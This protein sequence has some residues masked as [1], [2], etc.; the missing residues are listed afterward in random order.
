MG[1]MEEALE[2]GLYRL[3][4]HTPGTLS[5]QS[6]AEASTVSF[7][8]GAGDTRRGTSRAPW[9]P[10]ERWRTWGGS[11]VLSPSPSGTAQ[12]GHRHRRFAGPTLGLRSYASSQVLVVPRH[13]R[14]PMHWRGEG[15]GSPLRRGDSRARVLRFRT[16]QCNLQQVQ[17]ALGQYA[18]AWLR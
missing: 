1:R 16:V 14:R 5:K 13:N 2:E 9:R 3:R 10:S 7:T 12:Y 8:Y 4:Q 17:R 15:K 11:L 6:E 18:M